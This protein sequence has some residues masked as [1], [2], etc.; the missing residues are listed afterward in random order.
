MTPKMTRDKQQQ[1]INDIDREENLTEKNIRFCE[2]IISG[3]NGMNAYLSA[4]TNP[5]KPI[6]SSTAKVNASI[7]L[8]KTNIKK[9]IEE[10]KK[11]VLQTIQSQPI[12]TKE[13]ILQRMN[14]VYESAMIGNEVI[15]FKDGYAIPSGLFNPD[16]SAA[17]RATDLQAKVIG[18][19][20]EKKGDVIV[21]VQNN[22]VSIRNF[23]GETEPE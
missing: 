8:T 6:K 5:E 19:Y 18:A 2:N 14:D 23:L 15:G 17:I 13:K 12:I 1:E 4:Y 10:R 16:R 11:I 21:N 7:L 20:E 22:L 3:M 9:Y